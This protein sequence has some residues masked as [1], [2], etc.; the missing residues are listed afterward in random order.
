MLICPNCGK[1]IRVSY[2]IDKNGDKSRFC[3][4]CKTVIAVVSAKSGSA[5]GGKK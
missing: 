5:S 2:Q 1:K 4:K 3:R